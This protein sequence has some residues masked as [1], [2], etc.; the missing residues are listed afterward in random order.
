MANE[1][2]ART[3]SANKESHGLNYWSQADNRV[4]LG[5]LVGQVHN[6]MELLP[7]Q[8]EFLEKAK[9]KSELLRVKSDRS[10]QW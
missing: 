4:R 7:E 2:W 9:A 10:R 6:N 8:I 5:A 3:Y 1:R